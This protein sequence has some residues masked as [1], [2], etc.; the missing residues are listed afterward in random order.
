[1]RAAVLRNY[2]EVSER[3]LKIEDID[4]EKPRRGE[5]LLKIISAG[6]CHSDMNVIEGKTPSPLP[7]VL[8]HEFVGKVEE[9]GEGVT[10]VGE[11]DIVVSSFIWPCGRCYNCASGRENLCTTAT[12]IRIKGVMLDGTTRL[13]SLE[14]EPI[15]AFL[16]GGFAEYSI[17][18][19]F[20][21]RVLPNGLRKESSAILG[22]AILTAYGAVMNRANVRAGQ[23]VAIFGIGGVGINIVQFCKISGA[24]QIITVDIIDEKCRY[25]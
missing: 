4:I 5:V 14:G 19:E 20:A 22:C 8:G 9:V 24:S 25:N 16:G 11:G 21:V 13:R 2:S 18:P 1:M 6:V 15:Y 12:P 17:V 3:P 23:K 10:S 7:I